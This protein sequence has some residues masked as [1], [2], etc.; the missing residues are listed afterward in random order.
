MTRID[1]NRNKIEKCN[2]L[3]QFARIFLP[4]SSAKQ[5]RA[6]FMAIYCE[7]KN[8]PDQQ[9]Q[10]TDHIAEKYQLSQS[11]VSKA[12]AKMSKQGLG[13]IGMNRHGYYRLSDRLEGT[14]N[15]IARLNDRMKYPAESQEQ[16]KIEKM[17]IEIAKGAD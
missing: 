6:A 13:I 1:L 3:E 11:T 10:S 17:M 16:I 2:D 8:A 7:I 9:I 5:L 4:Q 14:L 15:M 12:R